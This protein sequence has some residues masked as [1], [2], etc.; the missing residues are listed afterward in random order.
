MSERI[1][2]YHLCLFKWYYII[3]TFLSV[4]SPNKLR[5]SDYI[6]GYSTGNVEA[7]SDLG[8]TNKMRGWMFELTPYLDLREVQN[9]TAGQQE[10]ILVLSYWSFSKIF[11]KL[12]SNLSVTKY[13]CFP[14]NRKNC[15]FTSQNLTI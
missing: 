12:R 4:N 10:L 6:G 9:V 2:Q 14:I 7:G 13:I 5:P 8:L 11:L 3:S 15:L 1:I